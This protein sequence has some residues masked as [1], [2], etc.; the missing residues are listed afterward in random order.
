VRL[1]LL[2]TL[3]AMGVILLIACANVAALMLGQVEGRTTE[4]AVRAAL[5]AGRRRLAQQ[6]LGE[7][8]VVGLA[9]GL[10]G[11]LLAWRGFGL[12]L[13]ALPLGALGEGARPDW[14]LFGA[15]MAIAVLASLAIALAPVAFLRRGDLQGALTRSRTAGVGGR[16]RVESGLVVAEVALAVLLAAGAGLFIRSVANLRAIDPGVDTRGIAVLDLVAGADM[17]LEDRRRTTA[18]LLAALDALPGV[19]AAGAVQRLPLRG[20]GDNWG[21]AVEGRPDLPSSTTSYRVATG[22]YFRALGIG[23]V[24]GRT[25]DASD[26][27]D[28]EP[29]VVINEALRR[30]YFGD[31][32]PIGRR[33]AAGYGGWARV[34]GV[35]ENAAEARLTDEP[36]PARYMS[37]EQGPYWPGGL[38]FVA[39]VDAG[40]DPIAVLDEARAVVRRVAPAIAVQSATTMESVLT[41]ALG[42]ARHVMTLLTLLTGLALAL[43]AIGIYGITAQFV[44]RRKRDWGIRLALGLTPGQ[45]VRQIVS[46]GAVLVAAGAAIGLVAVVALTRLLASLL[47]AVEA[48]DPA[49]LGGAIAVLLAVGVAAAYIPAWRASRVHPAAVL[50]EQ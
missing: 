13:A 29:V 30:Q 35:V 48:T 50:R 24:A 40:R 26:R 12:L 28:G 22:G 47:Y 42:P 6:L 17:S 39:R 14:T 11:A 27:A 36:A 7:A 3:G 41:Q 2:A 31:A 9:A 44:N 5:G 21:M 32:D 1:P 18:E 43:G 10:L 34:I 16:G 45:V 15:A 37:Y 49:S 33:I 4:L 25:F 38:T 46:H 20:G 19:N 8:L 23:V